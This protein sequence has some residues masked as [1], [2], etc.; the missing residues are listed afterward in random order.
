[1]TGSDGKPLGSKNGTF[2]QGDGVRS[3]TPLA[4]GD[5]IRFGNVEL[6]LRIFAMPDS[7]KTA[8]G[9]GRPGS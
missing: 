7:T 8:A 2:L 1:M 3:A 4:D 9:E 5:R 6:T